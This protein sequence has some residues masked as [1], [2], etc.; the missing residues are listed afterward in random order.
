MS[1]PFGLPPSIASD[2]CESRAAPVPARVATPAP[3][4]NRVAR[5][6]GQEEGFLS[7][8]HSPPPL[9]FLRVCQVL[10][11]L[12]LVRGGTRALPRA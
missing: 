10:R 3:R 4:R 5:P 11:R 7:S 2:P 1:P 9:G 12:Q 8:S 6:G